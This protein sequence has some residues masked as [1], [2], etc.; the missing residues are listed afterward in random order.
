MSAV[1]HPFTA[2]P[3]EHRKRQREKIIR[4]LMLGSTF[5]IIIPVLTVIIYLFVKAAPVLSWDYITQNP[6]PLGKSGGIWLPL[7]GTFYLV[8]VSLALVAPIGILA[9]VVLPAGQLPALG[10]AQRKLH[11]QGGEKPCAPA[12]APAW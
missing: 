5:A 10:Q 12:T 6:S 9:G 8:L 1:D 3:H 2:S 7:M 4:W 11:R